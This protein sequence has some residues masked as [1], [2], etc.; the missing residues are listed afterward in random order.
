MQPYLF[1]YIG[2]FQL[3]NAVDKFV[4]YDDVSFIKQGW[5]NKNKILVNNAAY[6]FSVPLKNV[7][8]FVHINNTLVDDKMYDHWKKKFFR[9]LEQAY[10]KAPFFKTVVEGIKTV[11]E[12]NPTSIAR[13]ALSSIDFVCNYLDIKTEI[14]PTSSVYNN[15]HLKSE[16]RVIDLCKKEN[17]RVYIN[18]AG[19]IDIYSGDNFLREGIQLYF[20]QHRKI[21]YHQFNK[22]FIPFLS[23]IDVMMFNSSAEISSMLDDFELIRA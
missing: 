2:Y 11:F 6:A 19:G 15:M 14:V 13:L 3:V 16:N 12:N 21:S 18:A 9:T 8:S 4:I 23:I 10:G 20:L 7:S 17:A 1:P 22:E 5:I